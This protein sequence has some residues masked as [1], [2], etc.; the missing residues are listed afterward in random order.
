MTKQEVFDYVVYHMLTQSSQCRVA[1]NFKY[2]SGDLRSPA[3]FLIKSDEYS[4][5]I[6]GKPL[7]SIDEN[8]L[9]QRVIDNLNFVDKLEDIHN[10]F[11]MKSW[12]HGLINLCATHEL[13]AYVLG[14]FNWNGREYER[15]QN[16][17]RS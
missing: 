6:E 13:S 8:L 7:L 16:Y 10:I 12:K 2:H 17:E 5:E 15:A 3:G 9:P 4:S 1:G 11:P 14:K